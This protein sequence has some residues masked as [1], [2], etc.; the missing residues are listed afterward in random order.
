MSEVI[1]SLP[2]E[3]WAALDVAHLSVDERQACIRLYEMASAMASRFRLDDAR[4]EVFDVR[5]TF[6]GKGLTDVWFDLTAPGMP[7]GQVVDVGFTLGQDAT[8]GVSVE[9]SAGVYCVLPV[10]RSDLLTIKEVAPSLGGLDA[11]LQRLHLRLDV[12]RQAVD[13]W[14]VQLDG[15]AASQ[16]P[17][18]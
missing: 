4:R 17:S 7:P 9:L 13:E 8:G 6:L 5:W 18:M 11:A 10:S 15:Q 16:A 3:P 2:G 14:C 12:V 1:A